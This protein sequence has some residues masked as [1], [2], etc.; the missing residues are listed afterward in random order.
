MQLSAAVFALALLSQGGGLVIKDIKVGTG[1]G[2][3]TGDALTVN[4]VGTLTNG[5]K[6]D[7]SKDPGRTPFDVTLGAHQVIPGWEQ[8]LLGMKIGGTRK[9]VIPPSLAYGDR[10]AGGVI[11]PNATIIFMVDLLKINGKGAPP[12]PAKAKVTHHAKT[13][14]KAKAHKGGH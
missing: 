1:V 10:G 2:A 14:P 4:Y 8:G 11:P 12:A 13:K 5:T 6:F 3:K 9:L 7:S